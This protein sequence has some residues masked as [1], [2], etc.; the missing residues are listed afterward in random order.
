[1]TLVRNKPTE[2]GRSFGKNIARFCEERI[3]KYAG[4]GMAVPQRCGTCAFREGTVP[5]GC[6]T[7]VWDAMKCALE[8]KV[9]F[10]CHEHRRDDEPPI[11]AG[12]L[13]LANEGNPT[14][15]KP[16]YDFPFSD[17]VKS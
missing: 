16:E 17:E 11:C 12:Y 8:G 6:E 10:M 15:I 9:R 1:M 7:T 5:N 3:K 4:T 14:T 13:L 2:L